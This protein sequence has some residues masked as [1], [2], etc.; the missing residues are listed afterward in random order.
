MNKEKF[1]VTGMSCAA[2]SARVEKAVSKVDGVSECQVNLLTN[3]MTVS[4]DVT[5]ETIIQAVTNAGYGAS[6]KNEDGALKTEEDSNTTSADNSL[7][8]TY[9]DISNGI[10]KRLYSSIILLIILMYISMGHH[11]FNLPL[12]GGKYVNPVSIGITELILSTIILYINRVF[13][14]NGAKGVKALAP[15]MDTLVALGSGISYIY[16]I[17]NLYIM[18]T[19]RVEH[20]YFESAAM[21]VTLISLGKLLEARS[22]GKTT[23]ALSELYE[24]KPD[25][26]RIVVD[27]VEKIIPAKDVKLD[28]IFIVKPGEKVPVD[29]VVTEGVT[30][31]DESLLTGESIPQDKFVGDE[32]SASTTNQTGHIT[33]KATR[34]GKDTT[35]SKIIAL[36]EDASASKAPIARIA[37]KVAGVFVPVVLLIAIITFTIW[38]ILGATTAFAISKAIAVLVISCP[39]ALGLATP[40]AIMV[41]TGKG[42]KNKIL[43]KNATSLETLAKAKNI[44]FDKTGTITYGT[45]VV[46]DILPAKGVNEKD[47]MRAAYSL[48]KLSEHPL[49]KA[50]CE[51]AEKMKLLPENITDFTAIPGKGLKGNFLGKTLYGGNREYIE[52][53]AKPDKN[54]SDLLNKL[55][56][57]GKT[58][59]LFSENGN[60]LGIIAVADTIKEDSKIAIEKLKNEGL[61]VIMLTGDN[62]IT[63]KAIAKKAGITEVIAG[64][65]PQEKGSAIEKLKQSG[66]TVMVGDGINDAPALTIAD[67]GIAVGSGTDIALE[68]ADIVLM[69]NSLIGVYEAFR[70]SKK[71]LK[72]IYENLFWAFFYNIICIP[73]AAGCYYKA[74]GLELSPMIG[75]LA[76][77]LSSFTVV[78]NALRLNLFKINYE[79]YSKSDSANKADIISGEETDNKNSKNDSVKE[80]SSNTESHNKTNTN[81]G[82][83]TMT[84]ELKIDGMMCGHCEATVKKA[85]EALDG[86]VS[87]EVSH[88]KNNA[89]VTL[90]A[91]VSDEVL[92]TTVEEKDFTVTGIEG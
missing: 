75:A 51:K 82:D 10:F 56:K 41:G 27:G 25:T 83:N 71:T 23:D 64:V 68:S 45:P 57:E 65:L 14:I 70:L 16:S 31:I 13:F 84:K 86:V 37:D 9:D 79:D 36:V 22:K 62:E 78:S 63:A 92:K 43:Y 91:E 47:L 26:A 15:N 54:A 1:D 3:S 61:K 59:M 40:V 44:V 6:I 2:C 8:K 48:E 38:M 5:A 66:I 88:E 49:A 28:D 30:S 12:P 52:N 58:P 90:S 76:M 87:A 89:I 77:S 33:C 60:S 39:C 50:I 19:G 69:K 21:I 80:D 17:I 46:T 20:L 29:G 42:A 55:S 67:V 11:M 72:N 32:V 4:G 24:L 35:L 7:K 73:L 18:T 81:K 34:V 74:F 53:I 85:L